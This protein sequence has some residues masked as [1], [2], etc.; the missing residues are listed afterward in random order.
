MA[1]DWK[2]KGASEAKSPI[3]S[4]ERDDAKQVPGAKLVSKVKRK[5]TSVYLNSRKLDTVTAEAESRG[6]SV[7]D[8]IRQTLQRRLK[9]N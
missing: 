8:F 4:I 7:S 9:L 2:N 1:K 3:I 5:A 6:E